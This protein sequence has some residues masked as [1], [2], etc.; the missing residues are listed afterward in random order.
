MPAESPLDCSEMG[1]AGEADILFNATLTTS[2]IS[3][4][5]S[6]FGFSVGGTESST[7]VP[8]LDVELDARLSPSTYKIFLLLSRSG[9]S[10][11]CLSVSRPFAPY[12]HGRQLH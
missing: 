8:V 10:R 3:F 7:L 5:P 11:P 2:R 4:D 1:A 9:I 12:S 6:D